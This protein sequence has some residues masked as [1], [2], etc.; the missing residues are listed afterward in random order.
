MRKLTRY[1]LQEYRAL[2]R[3]TLED[4]FGRSFLLLVYLDN[5][6]EFSG[7]Y[8]TP[9]SLHGERT[10]FQSLAEMSEKIMD[11]VSEVLK[12]DQRGILVRCCERWIEE[13]LPERADFV[14]LFHIGYNSVWTGRLLS[15]KLGIDCF[16]EGRERLLKLL[17]NS[18][19]IKGDEL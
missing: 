11:L 1:E 14:I 19:K 7:F 6:S 15:V 16:Y 5:K 18:A 13:G 17:E 8:L 2:I 3:E 12:R 10:S 4:P 9:Y